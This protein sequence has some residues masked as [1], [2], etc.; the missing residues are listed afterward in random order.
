MAKFLLKICLVG[1]LMLS[2]PL[3]SVLPAQA[4]AYAKASQARELENKAKAKYNVYLR[5]QL[6]E[7]EAAADGRTPD[8]EIFSREKEKALGEYQGIMVELNACK[9]AIAQEEKKREAEQDD[10]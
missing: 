8:A 6:E 9:A 5:F 3:A 10:K 4:Q 2:C 1:V 7:Q